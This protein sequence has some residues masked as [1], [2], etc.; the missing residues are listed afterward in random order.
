LRISG[1]AVSSEKK[2]QSVPETVLKRRKQKALAYVEKVKKARLEQK[3]LKLKRH[4][5]FKRAE[6]YVHEYNKITAEKVRLHRLARK[7]NC[8]Y[9]PDEPKLAFVIR[10][11]GINGVHPRVRKILQLFRLRQINNGVF[12]KINKPILNMLR[13]VEPYVAWGYPNLKS[14]KELV[15]KRGFAK[16]DGQRKAITD[17][18]MIEKKLGK[19]HIICM[20][21]LVHEI[22]TVGPNFKRA[23]NFLWPFKLNTPNGGWKKKGR[24][25]VEGGDAGNRENHINKLIRRMV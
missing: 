6:K 2:V 14:V 24:H 12:M 22:Y 23:T 3:K 25:F 16:I 17:N 18:L 19:Y 20:E 5:I 21:D 1:M 9:V 4:Q 7:K 15:Y 10:I 11:K 8:F 13:I